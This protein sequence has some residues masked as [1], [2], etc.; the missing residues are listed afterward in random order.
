MKKRII[1]VGGGP[2]GM[3]A[4]GAAGS[5]GHD[6]ILMEKNEKL[7]KKLYITGKGRCNISNLSPVGEYMQNIPQNGRFLYSALTQFGSEELM[8]LL[9][10]CGL[11]TKVERG[12]RVFPDSDKA[13]DVTK[14]LKR[15]LER[16]NVAVMLHSQ[17]REIISA[18]ARVRSVVLTDG[19]EYACD[20]V[21]LA[22]GGLSYPATGSTGDGY[23]FAKALG[24]AIVPPRAALVP[25]ETAEEWPKAL[26]GLTL[27]NVE[28]IVKLSGKEV[29]R[30]RGEMLFTH[31]GISG[32][33]VLSASSIIDAG[34]MHQTEISLDL[35]PALDMAA[36][37]KRILRDI[38][39]DPNKS[40]KTIL[41]GLLPSSLVQAVVGLWNMD[42]G[43]PAHSLSKE[44]RYEL[45]MLLKGLTLHIKAL[46]P[47]EEAVITRGG[48]DVR[49]VDPKTMESKLV[50]GLYFAGE[51][52]DIDALT[53]GFNLQIAFST[54]YAAG[55]SC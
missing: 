45:A 26:Q 29:F 27:K 48:V 20:A 30:E 1:V 5:R 44:K 51:M 18:A 33:L 53:G 3:M 42:T 2:A 24:H 4:A 17:V 16:G 37:D 39:N 13:S 36:L 14:A 41:S 8:A 46:R 50:D 6:V 47:L 52:L 34:R 38:Q 19:K 12:K 40:I 23:K 7:G 25:M 49:E 15:Y 21:I 22:T 10:N 31:F 11:E 55:I 9:K 32:P 28:L 43:I 54:G 35:K